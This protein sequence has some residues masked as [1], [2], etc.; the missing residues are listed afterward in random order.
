[1]PIHRK[2]YADH[3]VI[4]LDTM[5]FNLPEITSVFCYDDGRQALLLDAGTSHNADT[6]LDTLKRKGIDPARV[7][8]IA[9]THYHF[10]HGGGTAALWQ[11]MKDLN[12]RFRI[13]TTTRTKEHLNDAASHLT[14]AQT[15][16]GPFVGTMEPIPAEAFVIV[17]PDDF[18][19]LEFATGARIKLVHSPGHSADHCSPCVYEGDEAVFMFAGEAS[20]TIYN[21]NQILTSPTSM[22]PNFRY[23]P[24]MQSLEKLQQIKPQA[25]GFCH[26][27]VISGRD[28]IETLFT[29]HRSFMQNFHEAITGAF[30]E[31][32]S[33]GYVLQAT[34]SLWE[35]RFNPDWLNMPGSEVFYK[36]I[37]LAVTYGFLVGLGLRRPKYEQ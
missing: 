4:L 26:F 19:P 16:F 35:N 37:R 29:E 21:E 7:S 10:D 14:G 8:G 25:M 18:I 17:E 3:N 36:N 30:A 20:G 9:L 22:P 24:Y 6:I 11:R 31:N 1:M 13:Y 23:E 33:T 15:T 12:P 28:D 5:Q 2:Q 32:P 34:E 27:G